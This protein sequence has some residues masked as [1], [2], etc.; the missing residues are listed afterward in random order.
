MN[1]NSTLPVL[2]RNPPRPRR[3]ILFSTQCKDSAPVGTCLRQPTKGVFWL[4]HSVERLA[5]HPYTPL[6]SY[7][8]TPP[9]GENFALAQ[10]KILPRNAGNKNKLLMRFF[11]DTI[12]FIIAT[13]DILWLS[14]FVIT[15]SV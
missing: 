9:L 4:F 13:K 12:G 8:G 7:D 5:Q 11:F 3:G 1:K 14:K 10:L 6:P 15:K 2:L